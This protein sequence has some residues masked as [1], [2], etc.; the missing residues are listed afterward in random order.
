MLIRF[1]LFILL[2]A[3]AL[4]AERECHDEIPC[5]LGDRSYH[6]REPDGWDGKSPLPVLMHF[7]G[8]MRT[9]ALPV[10]HQRIS[11]A[12]RRRGV[13]LIAPNGNG[14][15]WDFWRPGTN[16][17]DFARAVLED[18]KARYPVDEQRV[19]VS[20]YSW[21]ANMA[22]RF[23]CE[24][25]ADVSALLAISGT[26]DQNENCPTA[27]RE[28]RE[29]YGL[30]DTVLD[31]PYGPDG[32]DSYPVALWRN[33]FNCGVVSSSGDWNAVSWLTFDRREWND[34]ETG[35]VTLDIHPAG[36]LIPRGWIA[37]QLDEL[38]GREP[39]YP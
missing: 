22:W 5:Q 34:C 2:A 21:G 19:F 33:K 28:V 26:L 25:G 4:A 15:S 31:Y 37:R 6:V 3:P 1:L 16:D 10:K 36:H 13:L 32:D 12:T 8:W 39:G 23:V 30:S 17:V 14:K 27:P 35:R 20:G 29:V 24:D 7:H 9:G 11:G 18:V 38:L